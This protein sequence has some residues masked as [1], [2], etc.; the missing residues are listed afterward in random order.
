MDILLVNPHQNDAETTIPWGI[1]AVGSYLVSRGFSVK[2][3]DASIDDEPLILKQVRELLPRVGLIGVSIMSSNTPFLQQL[4]AEVKA[5][6]PECRVLVGGSHASLCPEQTC[7][8]E[9]VDFVATSAGEFTT[10][11]LIEEL[12]RGEPDLASVPGLIYKENGV[13]HRTPPPPPPPWYDLDY[14]LLD[15]RV[16]SHFGNFMEVLAGRGCSFKCTFC[17]NVVTGQKWIGRPVAHLMAE[18][19]RVV[20]RY[21]PRTIF[22]RDDLF[23][24]N[25][26][27]IVEFIRIYREK[28]F[29]FRWWASCRAADFRPD[30]INDEMLRDLAE[31]NLAQLR[32]GVE[33]GSEAILKYIK[34]GIRLHHVTTAVSRLAVYPSIQLS[35]GFIIG[36]PK[37]SY[38][39]YLKTMGLVWWIHRTKADSVIKGPYMYRV[40][41]G[42]ELY[43][44]VQRDWGIAAPG[45]FQEW[46]DRYRKMG[47]YDD[48][49]FYPWI[50]PEHRVLTRDAFRIFNLARWEERDKPE[51]A[52][53]R[54]LMWPLVMVLRGR[55]RWG[56][57]RHLVDFRL[58]QWIREFSWWRVLGRSSLYGRL[59]GT[60]LYRWFKGTGLFAGLKRVMTG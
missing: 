22:F 19:E 39:D 5:L 48:R 27:R 3:L 50:A 36:F 53:K 1:L 15:P 13:V 9:N 4:A 37:E 55:F 11:R 58:A 56:Y 57:F 47:G 23:F 31:I 41:P 7:A 6:K 46:V 44:E 59:E 14:E 45:S 51:G 28:G 40:Y 18:V 29:R 49:I 42:G 17:Y 24:H 16:V 34:K 8:E 52:V 43:E 25:R 54:V 60:A 32:F 20:Q 2:L 38:D 35:C 33:S 30:Y 12:R 10:E 21:N 26:E